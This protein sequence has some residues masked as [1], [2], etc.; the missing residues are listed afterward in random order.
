MTAQDYSFVRLYHFC[1]LVLCTQFYLLLQTGVGAD[2]API[3]PDVSQIIS[4]VLFY[5]EVVICY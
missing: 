1:A 4:G 3:S 2:G 5:P